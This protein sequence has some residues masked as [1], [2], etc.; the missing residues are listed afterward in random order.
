MMMGRLERNDTGMVYVHLDCYVMGFH[1][2]G[3]CIFGRDVEVGVVDNEWCD[4]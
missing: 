2:I 1:D 4:D 3:N